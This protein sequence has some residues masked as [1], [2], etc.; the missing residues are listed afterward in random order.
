MNFEKIFNDN[1]II[2]IDKNI[3]LKCTE[4]KDEHKN[5]N[6]G[7]TISESN[8][9]SNES[10]EITSS[11]LNEKQR[12][13]YIKNIDSILNFSL[14]K[15][16]VFINFTNDFWKYIINCYKKPTMENISICHELRKVFIKYKDLLKKK[17]PNSTMSKEANECYK[18]DEFAFVLDQLVKGYMNSKE[19]LPFLDKLSLITTYNPYYFK[20][21]YTKKVDPF[22]FNLLDLDNIN[23]KFIKEYRKM[24]FEVIF[25]EKLED[26][27]KMITS[28]INKIS[29]FGVVTKL[30]DLI[31]LK[32]DDK[33]LF[34]KLSKKK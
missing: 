3:K 4:K 8:N 9:I 30:I 21:E 17:I 29:N 34:F 22:I 20:L 19:D 10:K 26:Y 24:N 14:N 7:E 5:E 23:I 15:E 31:I 25:H 33:Y 2:K 13:N 16:K 27:I 32:P 28:K 12:A 6:E 18:N 11:I 1:Y